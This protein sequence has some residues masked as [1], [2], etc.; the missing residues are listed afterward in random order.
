MYSLQDLI[1]DQVFFACASAKVGIKV[2]VLYINICICYIFL[3]VV[4]YILLV[5]QHWV[6]VDTYQ[7]VAD[8]HRILYYSKLF[9]TKLLAI[10]NGSI[11]S[12]FI[13]RTLVIGWQ[14]FTKNFLVYTKFQLYG[15]LAVFSYSAA[16]NQVNMVCTCVHVIHKCSQLFLQHVYNYANAWQRRTV[17]ADCQSIYNNQSINQSSI[18]IQQASTTYTVAIDTQCLITICIIRI[19]YKQHI[20]PLYY[21]QLLYIATC[22][23]YTCIYNKS[24][25]IAIIHVY[26]RIQL[27]LHSYNYRVYNIYLLLTYLFIQ[28]YYMKF[29]SNTTSP[30]AVYG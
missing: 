7:S 27:L 26:I 29:N 18:P 10:S 12:I 20:H 2:S 24:K 8:K 1:C 3:H 19:I 17:L 5:L 4:K 22:R 21:S 11:A 28:P 16:F 6:L 25:N 13:V 14:Q 23:Q 30:L 15:N 9:I